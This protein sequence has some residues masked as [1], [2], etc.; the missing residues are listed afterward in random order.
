MTKYSFESWEVLVVDDEADNLMLLEY[1]LAFHNVQ[2]TSTRS[3]E[4]ALNLIKEHVYAL[5]LVDIQMP[6]VSGWDIV[7]QV[8]GDE[9]PQIRAMNMIAV[10]ALAM[11]GDEERILQS[12]FDGYISKPIDAPTFAQTVQDILDRA[13]RKLNSTI[14]AEVPSLNPSA[15]PIESRHVGDHSSTPGI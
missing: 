5:A 4:T 1:I 7:K 10:T 6:R 3:G 11:A 9:N 8:R 13:Q 2:V 14:S 15:D 12:G